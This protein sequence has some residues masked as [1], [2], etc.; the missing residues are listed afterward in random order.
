MSLFRYGVLV[1]FRACS[2][3]IH[4]SYYPHLC[5]CS[6]WSISM[7]IRFRDP[8]GAPA[9]EGDINA[10]RHLVLN[11]TTGL[12]ALFGSIMEGRNFSTRR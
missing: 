10:D 8:R 7:W 4:G 1:S 5:C 6:S 2:P 9:L 3:P 12:A 11:V